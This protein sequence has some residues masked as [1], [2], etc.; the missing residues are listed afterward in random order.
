MDALKWISITIFAVVTVVLFFATIMVWL[1]GST[2]RLL[3]IGQMV[4]EIIKAF[5]EIVDAF[6]RR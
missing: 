5:A 6:M 3:G 4:A 1:T 2:T